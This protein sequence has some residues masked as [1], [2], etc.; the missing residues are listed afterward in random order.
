[1]WP[2]GLRVT[3]LAILGQTLLLEPVTV[4]HLA[5]VAVTDRTTLTRNLRLPE[6][7]GLIRIDRGGGPARTRGAADG[8]G[9][10]HPRPHVP[11]LD[12][13][14]GPGRHTL[15]ERTVRTAVVGPLGVGRGRQAARVFFGH[16][17]V[18]TC[19]C[20][21]RHSISSFRAMT[22]VDPLMATSTAPPGGALGD[23]EGE[24]RSARCKMR[25]S[26]DGTGLSR[27]G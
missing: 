15:R 24:R 16:I 26:N 27:M 12:R 22:C 13:G 2:F 10:R 1:M 3:P 25:L 19:F 9:S 17:G 21:S 14:A 23:T 11:H 20:V 18:S 6:Q 5:E 4:T 8:W 7:R